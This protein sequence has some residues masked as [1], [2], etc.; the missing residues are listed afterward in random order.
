VRFHSFQNDINYERRTLQKLAADEKTLGLIVFPCGETENIDLLS[1]LRVRMP[2]VFIDHDIPPISRYCISSDNEH[3]MYN[4]IS[5]LIRSGHRRIALFPFY[6]TMSM[7]EHKRF[8][9]YCRAHVEHGLTV[10]PRLFSVKPP[11]KNYT[12][13]I[14][15]NRRA[16]KLAQHIDDAVKYFAGMQNRP[17]AIACMNDVTARAV[18]NRLNAFGIKV[19]DDISVTGFDGLDFVDSAP[20]LT[21]VKQDFY[22]IGAI[23]AETLL[24]L[25]NGKNIPPVPPLETGIICGDTVKT[26]NGGDTAKALN[27][28][29]TAKA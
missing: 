18:I 17:T 27:G 7:T 2:I 4:L 23:A 19:P 10:D 9:G 3:G 5:Y 14:P 6:K 24:D 1:T 20:K 13:D 29:D 16:D 12:L 21:T 28:G 15:V 25:I 22:N 8:D 11:L 26:L